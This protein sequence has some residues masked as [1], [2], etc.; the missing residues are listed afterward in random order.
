VIGSTRSVRVYAYTLPVDMRKGFDGLHGI[1]T[2]RLGRDLK[3][4]R[5][6]RDASVGPGGELVRYPGSFLEA[7]RNLLSDRGWTYDQ[8]T[9]LWMPPE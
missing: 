3:K 1:I 5:P 8:S 6:I 9:Q 2:S 7:E 4:G